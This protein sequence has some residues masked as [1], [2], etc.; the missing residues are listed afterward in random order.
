M[1]YGR[2]EAGCGTAGPE[3]EIDQ[4]PRPGEQR[5]TGGQLATGE[6]R[7]TGDEPTAEGWTIAGVPPEGVEIPDAVR[8]VAAG[9]DVTPVWMNELGG[10]TV[11]LV[12]PGG[13]RFLKWAPAR[14]GLDLRADPWRRP[15]R[16][17]CRG[18]R[19]A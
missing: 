5:P 15:D 6:E 10:V 12:S 19:H 2:P 4:E 9:G 16:R 8:H 18:K 1:S 7:A 13:R 3:P 11:E 17:G 14:S